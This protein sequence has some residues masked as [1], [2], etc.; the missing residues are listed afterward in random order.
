MSQ[1]MNS[2]TDP[3]EPN[4]DEEPEQCLNC[5]ALVVGRFCAH[6]GQEHSHKVVSIWRLAG[7]FLGDTFSWDSRLLRTIVTLVFRPGRLTNDYNAGRRER[8]LSPWRIYV[9]T[10]LVLFYVIS[11]HAPNE[12][13]GDAGDALRPTAVE[14]RPGDGVVELSW[15]GASTSHFDVNR[16]DSASGP[17]RRVAAALSEPHWKDRAARNGETVWYKITAVA[18]DGRRA[19]SEPLSAR[20]A[21]RA[22]DRQSQVGSFTALNGAV[23]IDG[24]DVDWKSLPD[25]PEDYDARQRALPPGK[26]DEWIEQIVTRRAI[27]MRN[28]GVRSFSAELENSILQNAPKAMFALLPLFALLLK[29]L[30]ARRGRLYIE[31]L[32]FALHVH[33]FAF[34]V[35][36]GAIWLHRRWAITAFVVA[37]AV[38]VFT[39]MLA[40]Y[41]QGIPKTAVKYAALAVCYL[42]VLLFGAAALV[43]VSAILS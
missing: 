30:Y 1:P 7:E 41:R 2:S 35:L 40:V 42:V 27:R 33:A 9:F 5:G 32:V 20:P 29:L 21:A 24:K 4:Q 15:E 39:A 3:V 14:V 36:A 13:S 6:C 34:A 25:T 28:E 17:Y 11:L 37:V 12:A 19:A 8:Y 23:K 26:R 31:H 38:Y 43:A 10:S 18:K 22:A 16:A